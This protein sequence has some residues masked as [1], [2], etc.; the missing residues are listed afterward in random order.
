MEPSP[1]LTCFRC[2]F[3]L[4]IKC[5]P[6]QHTTE[7]AGSNSTPALFTCPRAKRRVTEYLSVICCYCLSPDYWRMC[8]E[9]QPNFLSAVVPSVPDRP[10]WFRSTTSCLLYSCLWVCSKADKVL[11]APP[12]ERMTTFSQSRFPHSVFDDKFS[13][14][15]IWWAFLVLLCFVLQ[16]Y[17]VVF[18]CVLHLVAWYSGGM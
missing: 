14:L 17:T 2:L 9:W 4:E 3:Q 18:C 10:N 16:L 13:L 15:E 1:P 5:K 6:E 11:C 12:L 7:Q 8:S